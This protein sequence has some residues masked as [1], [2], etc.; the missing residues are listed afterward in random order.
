V[1]NGVYDGAICAPR[2]G[3]RSDGRTHGAAHATEVNVTAADQPKIGEPQTKHHAGDPRTKETD[4][5]RKG[6]HRL[7]AWTGK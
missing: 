3:R 1:D 7:T 5:L 4:P 2:R 6:E